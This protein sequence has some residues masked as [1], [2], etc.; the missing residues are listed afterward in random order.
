MPE[1]NSSDQIYLNILLNRIEV[2]RL[3]KPKF[4]QGKTIGLTRAEYEQ[5]Y[6]NDL[7]YAWLGLDHSL[8]YAAHKAAGGITSIYRQIGIGC[9]ELFRQIVRDQLGLTTAQTIWSYSIPDPGNKDRNLSLDGH[10]ALADV[11]STLLKR[12]LFDWL[13][14]AAAQAHVTPEIASVP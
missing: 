1:L 13:Q 9:E 8:M 3:Y 14:S 7:F 4:G 12:Q 10:I 11:R 5:L 2:C 6:Q